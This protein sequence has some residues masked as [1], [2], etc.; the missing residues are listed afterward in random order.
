MDLGMALAPAHLEGALAPECLGT[1]VA[2][3]PGPA[4]PSQGPDRDLGPAYR[5]QEP[6]H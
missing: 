2:E 5:R 6:S 4:G 3:V 1:W